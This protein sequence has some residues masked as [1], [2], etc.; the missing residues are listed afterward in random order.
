MIIDIKNPFSLLRKKITLRFDVYAWIKMCE[1]AGVEFH[2]LDKLNERQLFLTWMYGAY[3]S[4]CAYGFKKPRYSAEYITRLYRWYY[5]NDVGTLDAIRE[6]MER[7][8]ILDKEVKEWA[9][10]SEKK[11]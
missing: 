11:K 1:V 2:E 4:A 3:L 8:K 7:S 10:Q 9:R 6:V 5:V